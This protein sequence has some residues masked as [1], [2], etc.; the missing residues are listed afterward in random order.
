ML[1][2]VVTTVTRTAVDTDDSG[3][4]DRPAEALSEYGRR[5]YEEEEQRKA[6][7]REARKITRDAVKAEAVQ[8]DPGPLTKP[9]RRRADRDK[10]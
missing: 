4:D 10:R 1:G 7:L 5:K 8:P 2:S 6:V 9:Q 3:D